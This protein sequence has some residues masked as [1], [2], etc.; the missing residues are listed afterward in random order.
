VITTSHFKS[1][2]FFLLKYSLPGRK[3]TREYSKTLISDKPNGLIGIVRKKTRKFHSQPSSEL[4]APA[5]YSLLS[6]TTAAKIKA[7]VTYNAG[8]NNGCRINF[9]K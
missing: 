2:P 5:I 3:R 6:I 4:V 9:Q 7:H 8:M 1:L